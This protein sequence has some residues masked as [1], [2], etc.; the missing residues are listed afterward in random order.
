MEEPHYNVYSAKYRSLIM[1]DNLTLISYKTIVLTRASKQGSHP[2]L[3][4]GLID[5]LNFKR[6]QDD[7]RELWVDE[8]LTI[9]WSI[10]MTDKSATRRKSLDA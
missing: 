6:T 1:V 7:V 3:G 2:S 5:R 10:R 8:L 9:L 4:L